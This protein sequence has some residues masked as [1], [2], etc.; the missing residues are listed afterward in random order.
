[1][2]NKKSNLKILIIMG[3]EEFGINT[4][5]INLTDF[6]TIIPMYGVKNSLNVSNAFS[7][8]CSKMRELEQEIIYD[9]KK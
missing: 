3:N 5:I 9:V 1:L 8:V 7:I 6:K 4:D 2:K